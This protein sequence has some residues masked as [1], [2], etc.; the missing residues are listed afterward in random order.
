MPLGTGMEVVHVTSCLEHA[1]KAGFDSS[2]LICSVEESLRKGHIQ[3]VAWL[4]YIALT[5]IYRERDQ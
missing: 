1:S 3:A 4:P 5:H 2:T